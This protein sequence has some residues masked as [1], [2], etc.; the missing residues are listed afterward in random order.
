MTGFVFGQNTANLTVRI[1]NIELDGSKIYI[2]VYDDESSFKQKMGAADSIT[3]I[4]KASP[5][6]VLFK[7]IPSGDYAIAVFQDINDNGKIDLGKLKIPT[8]PVGISNYSI[9]KSKLPPTFEKAKFTFCG[10]TL[11]FIPLNQKG[12]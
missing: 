8:E 7:D 12:Q 10:D 2:G 1:S 4:S 3:I 11:I 6:E 9:S 5:Q